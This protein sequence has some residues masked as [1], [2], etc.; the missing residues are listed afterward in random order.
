MGIASRDWIETGSADRRRMTAVK[1]LVIANVSVYLLQVLVFRDPRGFYPT[2]DGLGLRPQDVLDRFHLWQLVTSLFLH[3]PRSPLHL[4]FNMYVLWAFGPRVEDELGRRGFTL[5][6]FATGVAASLCYV[7]LGPLTGLTNVAVGSSGA[8][9]GVLLYFTLLSPETTVLFLFFLPM[10]M[11]WAAVIFVAL[12]LTLFISGG[13]TGIAHTAHLGG[14]A[15]G[16]AWFR[17]ANRSRRPER[18]GPAARTTAHREPPSG[19]LRP[20]EDALLDKVHREGL[21]SLTEAEKETLREAGRRL[22]SDEPPP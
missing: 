22:R 19:G 20:E 9:Y 5:F 11:K 7:G 13:A 21:A 17:W 15:A 18:R 2:R 12:D 16:F 4:V 6:F 14:A 10:K 1:A 8:I 3:D